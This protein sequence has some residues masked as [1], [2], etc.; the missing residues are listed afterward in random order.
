MT[1]GPELTSD[2][3]LLHSWIL[4]SFQAPLSTFVIGQLPDAVFAL[5]DVTSDP[6][7]ADMGVF[8]LRLVGWVW[9][10]VAL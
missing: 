6:I 3:D 8:V 1:Q 4:L 7:P 10:P 5:V 9:S 2:L